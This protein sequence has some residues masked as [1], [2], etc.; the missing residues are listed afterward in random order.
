[1]DE[2]RRGPGDL[3]RR[4]RRVAGLVAILTPRELRLR[5]RENILDVAWALITP[6]AIMIVYGIVLTQSLK[7]S[8]SCSP[9]L[10]SAWTGLV[11]WTFFATALGTASWSLLSASALVTKVYFPREALPLSVVGATLFDL[12]IGIVTIGV[13]VVIQ[14]VDLS[15]MAL[16][17]VVAFLMLVVW[18]AA[19]CIFTSVLAVFLR[20]VTQAVQLFLRVGFFATP[21]MYEPGLLPDQLAW[22]ATVNPLA[23]AIAAVRQP[24]L[25]GAAPDWIPLLAQ[26][27]LGTAALALSVLYVR[28]VE[29]RMTDVL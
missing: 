28:S 10:S 22:T 16:T 1:M 14:R 7:V 25:C 11:I 5:Y 12:V 2:Q 21:V 13:V 27:G 23:V 9:Y 20:D 24:V 3:T 15:L 26:L 19:V 18:T 4:L 8:G 29:S 17:A 6:V